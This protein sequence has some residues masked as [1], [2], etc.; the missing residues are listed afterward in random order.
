LAICSHNS[1]FSLKNQ[2]SFKIVHDGCVGGAFL[3]IIND[4]NLPIL[5]G[6]QVLIERSGFR[7]GKDMQESLMIGHTLIRKVQI[8]L[9]VRV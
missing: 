9:R 1:S 2:L 4:E 3:T 8:T 5:F 7:S 6:K